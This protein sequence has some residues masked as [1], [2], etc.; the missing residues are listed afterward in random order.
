MEL[1]EDLDPEEA[2][3]IV[4]PAL[5]LM[6]DAVHR[7]GG[8]VVQSTGDGI[9]AL[10]GAPVAHE[11][12]PQQGLYA[13]L[14]L[15]E[16]LNRYSSDLRSHGRLPL[17]ARVGLNTGDVVVRSLETSEAHAEY[18]PIGHSISLAA[19]M[20]ALAPVGSIAA[21]DTTRKL[22]EG[23]F[24]FKSLGP[25]VV[26][27][28]SEP[29]EVYQ[30]TGLGPLRTR[31]QHAAARG[32]TKFVGRQRE[33][34]ALTLAAELA[35]AGHGQIVAVMA[36]PG[37]GKSRLFHEFK[38]TSQSDWMMLEA[39]SV[40]YGKASAYLPF[41]ELLRDYFRIAVTDDLRTRREK[42]TG[43][44]L[45]LDRALEDTLP[46]LFGFLG[47]HEGDD[48]LAQMDAQVRRRRTHEA[49]KRILLRES[50]AQ[51]LILVFEDLHWI[52]GETQALLNVLVDAIATA[53]ILLLVNYR[54]EY[55][56]E[57]GSRTQYTQL[58]LDP[59]RQKTAGEMLDFLLSEAPELAPLKQLIV[60]RTEGNPFFIEE[61]VQVLLDDGALA[62]NGQVKLIKPL[63]ELKIPATVQAILSA[64]IDRL[65][66][67]EK[68][69]LQTLAVIGKTLVLEL[70]K[71]V[72][73]GSE[74]QLQLMLTDL[75][76][77]EFIYEQPAIGDVEYTFKHALT[78]DVAYNSLLQE[79]RRTLHER[80]GTALEALHRQQI[81]DHLDYLAHHFHRSDNAA[82]A[83]EYLRLAGEQSWR[84]SSPKEALAY[85][86]EALER[87]KALP[88]EERDRAELA[89]QFALGS[90]LTAE[91]WVAPEKVHAFERVSELAARTGTAAEVFPALWHL[92][93]AYIGQEKLARADE[94][95]QQCLRLAE[96]ANDRRKLLGGHYAVGEVSV[97]S[98]KLR[99]ARSHTL[100]AMQLYDRTADK[101]LTLYYGVDPFAMSCWNLAFAETSM[102]RC[103]HALKLCREALTHA[104]ELSH[105]YSRAFS[106]MGVASV[107]QMRGEA[108]H[109]E[110]AAREL[111][112]M[113]RV[114]GFS[115]MLGWGQWLL[116]WAAFEQNPSESGLEQMVES[117]TFQES[118]GGTPGTPWRRGAL[119]E[120][121]ARNGRLDDARRELQKAVEAANQTGGHFFDA[122]LCRI[123]GEIALRSDPQDQLAAEG[124]FRKAIAVA[125]RQ[126]A[127]WWELRGTI[128]LARLLR[129]TNRRDEAR[130]LLAEIYNWFTEGFD[131][132]DLKDAKVL[133]DELTA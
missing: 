47:L 81:D 14:R 50:L 76:I 39:L 44:V 126:E 101:D 11:D 89:V 64:R 102:G 43:R 133:L 96:S 55:R 113:C 22:C 128:S 57:W 41:L 132:A 29:I 25:T 36:E 20:Q 4:D 95:A 100:Q 75:Q 119:A 21:T 37:V 70:I 38:L 53:R 93:E 65:P 66:S 10:F 124:N 107:H 60:E 108:G 106:L 82:K 120:A 63:A 42:L 115:E 2:R 54:P 78:H 109:T 114:H 112:T 56:H 87:T 18:T 24:V 59:L 5:K 33:M 127:R 15:Q 121:Y 123:G 8:Y 104:T 1:M 131:T 32:L 73:H 40:S 129:D 91:S 125:E 23:Y 16:Q 103:D 122:E 26:K 74:E 61:M 68:E 27:G 98:G 69:L 88:A 34:E 58:R 79:R 116:G 28:V 13:A 84:R 67:A 94:L 85:L 51:P 117:I 105:L 17:Q 80:I 49:I 35:R 12:H 46:Y 77:A 110:D 72:T 30:V 86:R 7:Y 62:R 118:I 48:P 45:A 111:S 90:A 130:T 9:F 92:A 6:I 31:F 97:W 71:A 83:V 3:A 19:R 52:D 99:E